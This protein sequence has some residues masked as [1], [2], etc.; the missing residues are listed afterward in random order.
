MYGHLKL[1]IHTYTHIH[2]LTS[3]YS[4]FISTKSCGTVSEYYGLTEKL[5]ATG[6]R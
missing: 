2:V 5:T 6:R 4:K 1:L 3:Y